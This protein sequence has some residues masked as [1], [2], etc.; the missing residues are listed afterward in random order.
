MTKRFACIGGIIMLAATVAGLVAPRGSVATES[1]SALADQVTIRRDTYGVPHILAE[2]EEAAAFGMGYAQAEDH[3]VE[4]ARRFVSARGEEAKYTGAGLENDFTMKRY[5]NYD[6]AKQNFD[7]L[8]P[9]FQRMMH[10]YAAGFN[11]YVAKHRRELPAWIPAFDAVDVLARSK[12][13]VFR[14]SFNRGNIIRAVQEK[15]PAEPRTGE[16]SAQRAELA[17]VSEPELSGPEALGGSNMWGLA[18][19]RTASGKPILLGNPHQPWS[20][21]YWEAHIT[22]PGQINLFG[23]TYAGLPVLRHGFNEQLGW[24]HTVNNIDPEDIYALRLDPRQPEH[25]LFEG[26]SRPLTKKEIT[27]EIKGADG[28]L[29]TERR[30]YWYA[31]LGPIVHQTADKVFAIKSAVLDEV[32]FFEAWYAMGKAEN[33]TE[34]QAALKL[35]LL[36][37]FNLTYADV[38]GNVF[39]LWN[40]MLPKRLDDGTD[41]RLEVPGETG[42]YVWTEFHRTAELPQ[43]LNPSGGYVQNCNDPPWWTSLRNPLDPKKYP[44]YIEPGRTLG[45]RTQMSLEMLEGQ[46]KFSLAEVMRLKFNPKMLLADRVKPDLIKAI[47]Q[48]KAPSEDLQRG[49]AVL[50]AWD[51]RTAAESKGGV[52]FQRFWDTYRAA[53]RQPYAV[54][55][56]VKNP[57]KTPYGLAEASLA[58]KH[59]EEAVRWTRQTYGAE[60]VAWGQAHRIRLGD[61][62]LP[63]NGASGEYGL[64]HVVQFG[65][66]PDGKRVVGT[67]EKNRPMV[68]GGDG[69]IFAVEFTQP[70]TAYSLLAYGQTTNPASKHS[71]DQ[72]KLYA[73]HQF[74]RAWFTEAEI[75]ANLEREY[76]P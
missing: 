35:N 36:P 8:S 71:T 23:T 25:Y 45:L 22:V 74:K 62:D 54:A 43:L 16:R 14:F 46:E 33:W 69:W 13:E 32:R 59:F 49:L 57:A 66:A 27:V 17:A 50:E 10:A 68:G 73:A 41:Y 44:S 29:K 20:V 64:F 67:V 58:V 31:H 61:L 55:W 9:L 26:K 70:V 12:A 7:R 40:G 24:T 47:K 75:K 15:Y 48:V 18:G 76:R 65:Q 52:L 2:T 5:G 19:A 21:L 34:F 4:I 51:N 72:V 42:K 39:Y 6:A 1:T 28:A 11:R 38:D 63:A 60:S 3:A 30:T 53:A 37:M 56:D